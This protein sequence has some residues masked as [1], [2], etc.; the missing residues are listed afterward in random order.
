MLIKSSSEKN[1]EFPNPSIGKS[2]KSSHLFRNHVSYVK[3]AKI[4]NR[5]R[6][7]K[8]EENDCFYL[9]LQKKKKTN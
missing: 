1:L 4:I 8:E 6:R 3:S 5:E 2:L 7:N 9:L